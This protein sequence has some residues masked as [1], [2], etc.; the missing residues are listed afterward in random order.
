V[1]QGTAALPDRV[2]SSLH[3]H[4]HAHSHTHTHTHHT[5]LI[6]WCVLRP[7]AVADGE[8]IPPVAVAADDVALAALLSQAWGA[9]CGRVG[10]SMGNTHTHTGG[11]LVLVRVKRKQHPSTR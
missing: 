7:V 6:A 9:G 10:G 11:M 5:H 4:T 3:S 8:A 2:P 1:P